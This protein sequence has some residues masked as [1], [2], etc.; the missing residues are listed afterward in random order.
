VDAIVGGHTHQFVSGTVA[1]IPLVVAGSSARA[2]GRIVLDWDGRQVRAAR[3]ELVRA[4]ADS[5]PARTGDPIAAY[6]DSLE[7]AIAPRVARVV[8]EAATLFRGDGLANLVTDAMRHATG[9]DVALTNPGGIRRDIPAGPITAGI[10]FELIPFE[11]SL[12]TVRLT[13]AELRALFGSRPEK[14]RLS[15]MRGR[16]AESGVTLAHQ[17]GTPV[18][19]DSTY[20]LVTT[21]FLFTGGDGFLGFEA[22]EDV[23]YWDLL[24][25][26]A[27]EKEIA[28]A[29]R[30]LVPDAGRRFEAPSSR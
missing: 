14:V 24:L 25:R 7:N 19:D 5:L 8:G 2:L 9:A 13:G 6:A 28:G 16:A 20:V 17:D 29:G 18:R 1:G 27:V 22:G 4:W 3:T 10:V 23:R 15:G 30:P 12:V 21:N 26:A 11:N